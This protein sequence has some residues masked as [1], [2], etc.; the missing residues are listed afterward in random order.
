MRLVSPRS[1]YPIALLLGTLAALVVLSACSS[2]APPAPT[3]APAKQA[4]AAPTAAAAQPAAGA[5][6]T[7]VKYAPTGTKPAVPEAS[8]KADK[9]Y[10]LAFFV[11]NVVNPFWKA[12]RKGGD[13][14]AAKYGVQLT[15]YA[16]TQPDNTPEQTRIMEDVITKK[17][18]D[19]IVYV[20]TDFRAQVAVVEKANKAGIPI[21]NYCNQ[22]AGGEIVSYVGSDDFVIGQQVIE[23]LAK[24]MGG[25]GNLILVEG[26]PGAI[27][28]E[29]RKRGWQEALK[30]YPNFKVLASQAA[31]YS[32]AKAV[33]VT[34]NLL[35]SYPN[36]EAIVAANDEMALGAVAALEGV[37]MAG[38]VKVTG[39]D[40]L[41]PDTMA[42][43]KD[44]KMSGSVD[45]GG[46]EMGY[47]S[48]E[49]AVRHLNGEKLEKPEVVLPFKMI[50]KTSVDQNIERLKKLGLMQ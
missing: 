30:K 3:A 10:K 28:A 27:T 50:D 29:N 24:E 16:P 20:P 22:M 33:Q 15:H 49:L 43:I 48:V 13:D 38:K 35:Q 11:K 14:A 36:V 40:A 2:A 21:Y 45:Y 32:R 46:Y 42:A 26:V 34:E 6:E 5:V 39:V 31:D 25:K 17:D 44:G 47:K 23:W 8:L 4:A 19:G 41:S 18:V 12:S 7:K 9:P 1:R 37:K